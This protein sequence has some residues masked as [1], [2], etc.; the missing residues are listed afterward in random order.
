[1]YRYIS[2]TLAH[3]PILYVVVIVDNME[4]DLIVKIWSLVC[5]YCTYI[6]SII[7]PC[8]YDMCCEQNVVFDYVIIIMNIIVIVPCTV[9]SYY[10]DCHSY[11]YS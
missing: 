8:Y 1:M 10:C 11:N 5:K 3:L 7:Q 9:Y 6:A 4:S 2:G